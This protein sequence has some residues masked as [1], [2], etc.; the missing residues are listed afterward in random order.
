MASEL[1]DVSVGN[2]R[3]LL[4]QLAGRQTGG[5]GGGYEGPGVGEISE[6]QPR[7]PFADVRSCEAHDPALPPEG[8]AGAMKAQLMTKRE[9]GTKGSE[10]V[11]EGVVEPGKAKHIRE[12][13]REQAERGGRVQKEA[14]VIDKQAQPIISENHPYQ[15][16]GIIREADQSES[17][18][19]LVL[20]AGHARQIASALLSPREDSKGERSLVNV[21]EDT[22]GPSIVENHPTTRTDVVHCHD[23][24]NDLPSVDPGFAKG[25]AMQFV[26]KKQAGEPK[27]KD[28]MVLPG[29]TEA[30]VFENQPTTREGVV[31]ESDKL[32][33]TDVIPD[34]VTSAMRQVWL[35][36]GVLVELAKP[37]QPLSTVSLIYIF[38]MYSNG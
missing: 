15:R 38:E 16:H 10:A 21:K 29:A 3:Q 9:N 25:L 32:E 23:R 31:R 2:T 11:E 4:Q 14:I 1:N 13:L 5:G 22:E 20:A 24:I 6:N 7:A 27:V 36:R 30:G 34:K 26:Q 35:E 12:Q 18:K 28:V 17:E 37:N 8:L 33:E 19:G